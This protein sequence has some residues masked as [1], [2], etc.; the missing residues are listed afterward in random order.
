MPPLLK[1]YLRI[2]ARIGDGCVIDHDFRTTDVFVILPVAM[3][4]KRYVDHFGTTADRY[5]A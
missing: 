4:S 1:G 3:I 2:G 5:A